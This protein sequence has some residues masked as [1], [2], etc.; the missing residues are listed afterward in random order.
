M[1]KETV[2]D[3]FFYMYISYVLC[4]RVEEYCIMN[5]N[6][7]QLNS[8]QH[9]N[10]K[11]KYTYAH[12]HRRRYVRYWRGYEC[13]KKHTQCLWTFRTCVCTCVRVCVFS[14]WIVTSQWR[15]VCRRKFK[16]ATNNLCMENIWSG[17]F[18]VVNVVWC[19]HAPLTLQRLSHQTQIDDQRP[20]TTT[21][22]I[23]RI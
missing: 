10:A 8:T 16:C 9:S 18:C 12:T 4:R 19:A 22:P 17:A 5:P 15:R 7:S 3:F 14:I 13:A 21:R 20:T 1:P 2:Q 6:Q 23:D 11:D